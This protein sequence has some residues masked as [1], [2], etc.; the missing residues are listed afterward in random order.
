MSLNFV[1]MDNKEEYTKYSKKKKHDK[2]VKDN[3][4]ATKTESSFE[5]AEDLTDADKELPSGDLYG[6]VIKIDQLRVRNAP[7][8][9]ILCL[10]NKG[11]EVVIVSD[12][13]DIWYKV[14]LKNGTVGFCMKEFLMTFSEGFNDNRRC[15]TWPITT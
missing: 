8:G 9:D 5:N 2:F 6:K 3:K 4:F 13:D 12:F 10:I 11:D 1:D 15:K 14:Q 7:E